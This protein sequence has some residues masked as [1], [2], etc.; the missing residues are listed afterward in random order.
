MTNSVPLESNVLAWSFKERFD[1]YQM[2]LATFGWSS[3]MV[4]I[5]YFA[6]WCGDCGCQ[7]ETMSHPT[8][9]G[10]IFCHFKYACI[11]CIWRI[12]ENLN[13]L[14]DNSQNY[15]LVCVERWANWPGLIKGTQLVEDFNLQREQLIILIESRAQLT[16]FSTT[17]KSC[18]YEQCL[19]F[20]KEDLGQWPLILLILWNLLILSEHAA[21]QFL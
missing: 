18:F 4:Q 2:Y 9:G 16:N 12:E 8:I 1:I 6:R 5:W 14:K 19:N 10:H 15:W 7:C 20:W 3:Q 17:T 11:F 13:I 21:V